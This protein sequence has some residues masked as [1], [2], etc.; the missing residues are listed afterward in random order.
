MKNILAAWFVAIALSAC[1]LPPVPIPVE[2]ETLVESNPLVVTL[3]SLG[4]EQFTNFDLASTAAFKNEVGSLN[5]V[6]AIYL[7]QF[8]LAVVAP[9]DASIDFIHAGT[10]SFAADGK[11]EQLVAEIPSR[12]AD[13]AKTIELHT[14]DQT[15]LKDIIA[16]EQFTLTSNLDVTSPDQDTTVRARLVFMIHLN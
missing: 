1:E 2:G 4:F 5:K 6:K 16:S 13:G 8:T 9:A 15:N 3:N 7:D 11:I 14:F 12:P 10:F